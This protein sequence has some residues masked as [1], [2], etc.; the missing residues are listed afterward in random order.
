MVLVFIVLIL[1]AGVFFAHYNFWRPVK[2]YSLPRILM[3]HNTSSDLPSGMNITPELLEKQIQYLIKKKY[4]FL[5]ISDLPIFPSLSRHVVLTFDDGFVGNY[6]YLFELL[7]KYKVPATIYL[8]PNIQGIEALSSSQITEMQA[9]GLV[10][11]GA[12]TMTHVNLTKLDNETAQKEIAQ[13]KEAVENL[14]GVECKSFAYP[15]GRYNEQHVQMVKNAGFRTAVTTKKAIAA[16][17]H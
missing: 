14:T 15:Y 6:T 4:T 2:K 16:F 12:H 5:K 3:Y 7:K 1:V 10:E 13:S 9:S 8:T 11:F 17:D